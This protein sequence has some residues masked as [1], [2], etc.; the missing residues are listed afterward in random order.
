MLK[1]AATN[2]DK[3]GR[4]ISLSYNASRPSMKLNVENKHDPFP[5]KGQRLGSGTPP[6]PPSTSR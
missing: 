1:T 3:K 6:E 5:Q 4:T 2:P